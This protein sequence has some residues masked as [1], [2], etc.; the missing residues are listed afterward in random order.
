MQVIV[1][2]CF[3]IS[4]DFCPLEIWLRT[5][6]ANRSNGGENFGRKLYKGVVETPPVAQTFAIVTGNSGVKF[7]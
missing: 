4:V 5:N 7:L 3:A 2:F 1:I 6:Y